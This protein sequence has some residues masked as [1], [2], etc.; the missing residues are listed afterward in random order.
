MEVKIYNQ[1]NKPRGKKENVH[2]EIYEYEYFDKKTGEVKTNKINVQEKIQS[3]LEKVNY[4][5]MIER[6]ELQLNGNISSEG[7]RDFTSVPGNKV[8]FIDFIAKVS[9]LDEKARSQIIENYFKQ[10]QQ[11]SQDST[12]QTNQNGKEN[13]KVDVTTQQTEPDNSGNTQKD[14]GGN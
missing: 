6:G 14:N 10:N 7:V 9:Q 11:N 2:Q 5:K 1:Y 3:N 12:N 8:D 4:K 13:G